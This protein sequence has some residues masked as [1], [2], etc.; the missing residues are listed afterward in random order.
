MTD[1]KIRGAIGYKGLVDIQFKNGSH[2]HT[3]T[4]NNEGTEELGTVISIVLSGDLRNIASIGQRSASNIGLQIRINEDEW[5]DLVS[6]PA[7]ITSGVWGPSVN[8]ISDNKFVNNPDVIGKA[9]FSAVMNTGSVIRGYN[10]SGKYDMRLVLLNSRG[11]ALAYINEAAN[12]EDR[13]LPL[14]YTALVNGQDALIVW[15]M[16]ILNY[17]EQ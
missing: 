9:Q 4:V 1:A 10:V 17:K 12:K 5:R 7:T 14:L 6:V 13:S 15:S 11:A 8:S 16:F 2:K 3:L